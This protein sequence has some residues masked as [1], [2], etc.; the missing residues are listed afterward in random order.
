MDSL[1]TNQVLLLF[2]SLVLHRGVLRLS[3]YYRMIR[4]R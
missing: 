3:R 2:R 4:P 1:H